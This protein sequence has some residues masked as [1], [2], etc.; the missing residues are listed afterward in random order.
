[1]TSGRPSL[2]LSSTYG[3]SWTLFKSSCKPSK[4]NAR[5]SCESCC[6]KPLNLGAYFPI[7]H[8]NK[9][10]IHVHEC[11]YLC[12]HAH[13]CI[14]ICVCTC[15]YT[16]TWTHTVT[17]S[18]KKLWLTTNFPLSGW[19]LASVILPISTG[20]SQQRDKGDHT[21]RSWR[22]SGQKS[23]ASSHKMLLEVIE[24]IQCNYKTNFII[25]VTATF[26]AD[27]PWALEVLW[28][29]QCHSKCLESDHHIV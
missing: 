24:N 1:M 9:Q 17:R 8:W 23:I 11:E 4:R 19:E 6:W 15:A 16:Y 7:V 5:S 21:K 10:H 3:L 12:A 28:F 18:T 20:H 14:C 27:L 29:W 2:S 26:N 22:L 13:V 25:T